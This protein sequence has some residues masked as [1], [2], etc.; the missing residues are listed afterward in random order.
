VSALRIVAGLLLR[1]V[2]EA[3][4]CVGK[5]MMGWNVAK[6][7]ELTAILDDGRVQRFEGDDA[8]RRYRG[9]LPATCV[10]SKPLR[11]VTV[12]RG[13]HYSDNEC[14]YIER[15][16][17]VKVGYNGSVELRVCLP[18][19]VR[20]D[21]RVSEP[22]HMNGMDCNYRIVVEAVPVGESDN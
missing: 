21:D 3:I 11:R 4:D 19:E 13:R 7:I 18:P 1:G 8:D 16:Y 10:E 2:G 9:E 22:W 6:C 20:H 12:L 5:W 15:H 17:D 14:D